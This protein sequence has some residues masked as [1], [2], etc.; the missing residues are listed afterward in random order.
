MV[1]YTTMARNQ[2]Y[3]GILAT[4]RSRLPCKSARWPFVYKSGWNNNIEMRAHHQH[5]SLTSR[6]T[7]Q[8]CK[9]GSARTGKCRIPAKM[10]G[11]AHCFTFMGVDNDIVQITN[12]F[13][14][15]FVHY[16][17]VILMCSH[18]RFR[19]RRWANKPCKSASLDQRELENVAS[20]RRCF[21]HSVK[22]AL[23]NFCSQSPISNM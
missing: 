16:C 11:I 18:S 21:K 22:M 10:M 15:C 12:L 1:P 14:F 5:T 2:R 8:I 23:S 4:I 17:G 9:F 13:W 3:A 6:S 19:H 20:R 7:L